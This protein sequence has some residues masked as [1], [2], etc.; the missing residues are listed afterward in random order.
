LRNADFG[1][2]IEE[3]RDQFSI[4]I[5]YSAIRNPILPD[6]QMTD[7]SPQETSKHQDH[8]IAHVIGTTVRAIFI[9]DEA[10]H[11]LLDI[12]FIWMIYLDG[13][14]GLLP[15]SMAVAELDLDETIKAEL[16]SDI[17]LLHKEGR[18][19]PLGLKRVRAAPANCLIIEVS[20]YADGERR[21]ILMTGEHE[22]L[23]IDTSLTTGEISFEAVSLTA[24]AS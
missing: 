11:V 24:D 22:H 3:S 19:A 9:L 16:L 20:F 15:Q 23:V 12:G 14:M 6:S 21:R 13:E 7:W 18:D 4:R 1:L 5:P 10:A 2:R 8:V 17:S